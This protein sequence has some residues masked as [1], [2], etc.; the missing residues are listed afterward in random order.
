MADADFFVML[1][2]MIERADDA[3][4]EAVKDVVEEGLAD[5]RKV[6]PYQEGDLS[7]SGNT[8]V[9]TTSDGAEGSIDFDLVYARSQELT[10]GL[11][12][13]DQGQAHYLGGTLRKN[14]GRYLDHL[15]A[16]FF[17]ELG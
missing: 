16:R 11:R 17:E 2:E 10:E 1:D 5:A 13:Q 14:S 8:T 6:V 4:V 3:A 15:S 12:H 7:R 9:N